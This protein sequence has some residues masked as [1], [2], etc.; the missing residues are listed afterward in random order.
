MINTIDFHIEFALNKVLKNPVYRSESFFY[1]CLS[2]RKIWNFRVQLWIKTIYPQSD[3][4]IGLPSHKDETA[5][6]GSLY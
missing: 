6:G 1:V 3:P 5:A 4:E 2:G